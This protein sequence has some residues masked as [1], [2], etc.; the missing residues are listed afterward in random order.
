MAE[1]DHLYEQRQTTDPITFDEACGMEY[2]QACIKEALRIH[3]VVGHLL[4]RVVPEGGG[5]EIGGVHLPR[6]TVVGV[7]PW[8][9]ARDP[10][11]YGVDCEV[12]RPERWIEADAEALKRM[13]RNNLAVRPC[14]LTVLDES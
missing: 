14:V 5:M 1:V 9:A 8:V 13:E 4:E 11:V 7:S 3:P 2:L 10:E 12:F 6:G